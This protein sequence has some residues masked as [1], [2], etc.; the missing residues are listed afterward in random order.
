MLDAMQRMSNQLPPRLKALLNLAISVVLVGLA[1][2]LAW[3]GVATS[4]WSDA[5]LGLGL[6]LLGVFNLFT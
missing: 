1:I 5:A 6:L 2:P 3:A 4:S